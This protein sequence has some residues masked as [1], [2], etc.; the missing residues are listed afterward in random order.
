V[1]EKI[2]NKIAAIVD[3]F[4]QDRKLEGGSSRWLNWETL[5]ACCP[6]I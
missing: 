6:V 5:P 3:D 4:L 2:L 1:S